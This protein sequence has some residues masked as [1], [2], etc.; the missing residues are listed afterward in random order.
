MIYGTAG[1]VIFIDEGE[2]GATY[3]TRNI[4][5]ITNGMNKSCFATAH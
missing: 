4:L 5:F 1:G 2:R 3:R